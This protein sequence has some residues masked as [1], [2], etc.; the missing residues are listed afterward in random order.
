M[1]AG[2]QNWLPELAGEVSGNGAKV[3]SELGFDLGKVRVGRRIKVEI[4][5]ARVM[6]GLMFMP[7]RWRAASEAGMFP[8]LEGQLEVAAVG[9]GRT[10]LALSANYEPP[11]GLI[12]KLADRA[13]FHRVAEVTVHDF[14]VRIGTR[15]ERSDGDRT[16]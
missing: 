7:I 15:L 4:G 13:L 12:G 8:S 16:P 6:A 1:A 9:G 10:Q 3:L 5:A 11:L 14:L 2:A